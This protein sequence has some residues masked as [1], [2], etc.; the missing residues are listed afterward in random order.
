MNSDS[1]KLVMYKIVNALSQKIG[2]YELLLNFLFI[3]FIII[4][5]MIIYWDTINTK[6]SATSRCKRQMDIYNKNK[7][8]YVVKATD[9]SRQNLFSLT[10]DTNQNNTNIE[11]TCNPGKYVNNFN[12][13]PVKDMRKNKDVKVDKVCSCD[14]YYNVGMVNE[15]LV[16]DGEPGILRYMTTNNSDFFD[17]LIFATYS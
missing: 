12:N 11:C 4:I 5:S 6:V 16:Y 13:I 7:G 3:S 15:N 14:K 2:F 9:K 1:A 8:T 10:Y 17:N